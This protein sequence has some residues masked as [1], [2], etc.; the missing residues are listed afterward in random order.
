MISGNFHIT[1]AK[2]LY[3]VAEKKN[4]ADKVFGDLEILS[5]GSD[6]RDEH[7]LVSIL[8]KLAFLK[9]EGQQAALRAAFRD[10]MH[11]VTL[12]LL[13]ILVRS[14]K[15]RLLPKIIEIYVQLYYADKGI[16]EVR[17]CTAR[18]LSESES[19]TL[20]EKV[21]HLTG[22]KIKARFAV[23]EDLI[24]GVQLYERGYVTDYS[25]KNYLDMLRKKLLNI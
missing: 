19:R 11:E 17:V 15:C 20:T 10:Q 25:V 21:E 3:K 2:A 1:F 13:I 6:T 24:G 22:K 7:G 9:K 16:T 12:N 4:I 18:S 23:K 5:H 8:K 14:K